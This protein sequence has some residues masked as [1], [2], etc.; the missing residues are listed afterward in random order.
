MMKSEEGSRRLALALLVAILGPCIFLVFRPK[1]SSDFSLEFPDFSRD[2]NP[3][4]PD[5]PQ[6]FNPEFPSE[7]QSRNLLSISEEN[8][9]SCSDLNSLNEKNLRFIDSGW[10]KA[11]FGAKI[12]GREIALKFVN[13]RGAE[14]KKCQKN[15]KSYEFCYEISSEKLKKEIFFLKFFSNSKNFVKIFGFCFDEKKKNPP[16]IFLELGRP[17]DML[18]LLQKSWTQRFRILLG[19]ARLLAILANNGARLQDFKRRQFVLA[20]VDESEWAPIV[21][22]DGESKVAPYD[23]SKMAPE[24]APY[25]EIKL[26]DLDDL[27]FEEPKCKNNSECRIGDRKLPCVSGRCLEFNANFNQNQ[28]NANFFFLFLPGIPENLKKFGQK[29]AGDFSTGKKS[30]HQIL[31]DMEKLWILAKNSSEF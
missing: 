11:T 29:I 1:F 7:F 18:E 17:V 14:M 5:L 21:A 16:A 20:P 13:D 12:R 27:Q 8:F 19:L 3:E 26:A 22:P 24:V 28:A 6:D 4:F 9:F 30:I 25:D 2:L 10:T 23:E 15:G 31:K